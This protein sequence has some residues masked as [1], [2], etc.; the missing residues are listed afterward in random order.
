[1]DLAK[2]YYERQ[3]WGKCLEAAEDAL[4]I[5]EKPLEYLCEA[6]SWGAAPWDYAAIAAFR[7]GQYQK[8]LAYGQVAH[9]IDPS[10]DRYRSNL[11]F[12][13]A[14]VRGLEEIA[15]SAS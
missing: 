5:E 11:E 8:A 1:M 4:S 14:A 9:E 13:R 12:Y 7:L 6:E 10:D 2:L 3:D 15:S